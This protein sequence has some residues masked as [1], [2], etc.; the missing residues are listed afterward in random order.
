MADSIHKIERLMA[1]PN[2]VEITSDNWDKEVK[3]STSRVMVTL[4]S[5]D[6]PAANYRRSSIT[7][8]ESMQV[9]SR[10]AR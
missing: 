3:Y 6:H 2:L 7:L 9:A 4:Q 5:A 8:L 10:Q 1:N